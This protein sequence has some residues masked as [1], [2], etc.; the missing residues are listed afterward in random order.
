MFYIFYGVLEDYIE[1]NV[2]NIFNGFDDDTYKK[3]KVSHILWRTE[4]LY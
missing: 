2:S 4:R 1:V 3:K